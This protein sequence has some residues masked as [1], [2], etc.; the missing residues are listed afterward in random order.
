MGFLP[1]HTRIVMHPARKIYV[2][3]EEVI[4]LSNEGYWPPP[5]RNAIKVLGAPGRAEFEITAHNMLRGRFISDYDCYLAERLAYVMTGG[6]LTGS[7]LVHE[8]YLLE[9]ER[10][11]FLSLLG[12]EKTKARIESIL[13]HN[14]PLRN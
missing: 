11:I 2:A 9:L 3:K 4:R 12:E 10:E 5:V 7:A 13:M 1:N 6:N 8:N 14:K